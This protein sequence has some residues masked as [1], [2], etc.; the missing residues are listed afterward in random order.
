[1]NKIRVR[2]APS[3]T[4]YLHIGGARSALFNYLF[5][6]HNHGDFILRIED[7]DVA[8]NIEGA[9]ESQ[10]ND[11][12]WLGIIPDESMDNPNPQCGPYRQMEKLDIYQKFC[13]LLIEKGYAYECFCS[14]EDLAKSKEEQLSRGISSPRYDRRCLKL[15]KEE[16]EE[17]KVKG[18][19]PA[20][21]LKMPHNEVLEFD[22]MVRGKMSFKSDDIGDFVIMKSNGIPTYNFAVV[23][24]D[25]MMKI[26]HVLRG[27][28]H[29]SNTP[30]QLQIYKYLGIEP[31]IFG[32]LSII[33]NERGKKLSK[34]DH[35]IRQFIEEYRK[36][37]YLK[38]AIFN[39]L[40]LLGFSPEGENEIY[41]KEEA[42]KIFDINHLSSA[43]SMFDNKKLNW[44]NSHYIKNMSNDD[45]LNFVK[46]YV[47]EEYRLISQEKLDYLLLLFKS[48]IKSANEVNKLLDELFHFHSLSE[49]QKEFLNLDSSKIVLNKFLE[50]IY[51]IEDF[52]KEKVNVIFKEIMAETSLKG[53]FVYMPIR[54]KLTGLEHGIEIYNILYALGKEE[55]YRRISSN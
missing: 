21:R 11:L 55:I 50:K 15:S 44:M 34:R 42:I 18:I 1:M 38:E 35:D 19:K 36:A 29:L 7:T 10:T 23:I 40:F 24:D 39:F 33:T 26:S 54:L 16:K 28:E 17:L 53:K 12:K 51:N 32:H 20:I 52:S 30:K 6:K 31:P 37:G 25:Y 47:L 46:D 13:D 41:S 48:E 5:A 4:G 14:S 22:D 45:Y 49:E 43:P 8:R 3:P 27:E 9:I 2:Y